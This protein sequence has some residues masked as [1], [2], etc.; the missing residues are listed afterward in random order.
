MAKREGGEETC[1]T[2]ARLLFVWLR[3]HGGSKQDGGNVRSTSA[4]QKLQLARKRTDE[5]SSF[6]PMRGREPGSK[7][8]GK[9][10]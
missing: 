8:V 4:A 3:M 6:L 9:D 5:T 7:V 1:P 10:V 2:R